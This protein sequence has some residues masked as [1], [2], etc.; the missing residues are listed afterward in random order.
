MMPCFSLYNYDL[1]IDPPYADIVTA[2]SYCGVPVAAL[3]GATVGTRIDCGGGKRITVVPCP[4]PCDVW[5]LIA[6]AAGRLLT[7]V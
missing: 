6:S 1:L 4:P 7:V 2:A 3:M 5:G